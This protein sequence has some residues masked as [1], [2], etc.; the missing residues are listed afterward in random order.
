MGKDGLVVSSCLFI[1]AFHNPSPRGDLA[2]NPRYLSRK[3]PLP[4]R[5]DKS[6]LT[7]YLL[8]MVRNTLFRGATIMDFE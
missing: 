7:C 8:E 5:M 1:L 4:V 6:W 2:P 3:S